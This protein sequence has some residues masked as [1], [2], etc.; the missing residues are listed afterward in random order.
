M[1]T[2]TTGGRQPDPERHEAGGATRRDGLFRREALDHLQDAREHGDVLRLPPAW[3]RWTWPL[4]LAGA[5]VGFVFLAVGQVSEYASGP[6][7]VRLEGGFDLVA[8]S[9]GTVAEVLVVPGQAVRAGDALIRLHDESERAERD[10]ALREFEGLLVERLRDPADEGVR[11]ALVGARAQL[12]LA[13]ARLAAR[14]VVAGRDGIVADVRVRP[15][16]TVREGDL[17]VSMSPDRPRYS[18]I[19]LIPG[20]FR[21]LLA[22]GQELLLDIPGFAQARDRTRVTWVADQIVGPAE[23]RRFLGPGIGDGLDVTGPVV[24]LRAELPGTG[25]RIGDE[26]YDYYD[27]LAV[28]AEIRTRRE[29]LIVALVPALRRLAD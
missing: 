6:A 29:P 18:V 28:R 2:G 3:T 7:V 25:F 1:E 12:E 9:G 4:I 20:R 14:R 13:E 15:G 17:L 27:G 11:R 24:L 8:A 21:P 22:P 19:V 26:S 5:A 16:M 23:A 10:R